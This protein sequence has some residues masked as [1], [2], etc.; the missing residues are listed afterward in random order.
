ML[1][2]DV[3]SYRSLRVIQPR[4]DGRVEDGDALFDG[5]CGVVEE[6]RE[7]GIIRKA[8][9]GDSLLSTVDDK[10]RSIGKG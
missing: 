3:I 10:E 1:R 6:G 9:T 2:A 8:E 7:V 4:N 5:Q